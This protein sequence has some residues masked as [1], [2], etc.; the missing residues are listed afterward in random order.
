MNKKN[1]CKRSILWLS[2]I[3]LCF[4]TIGP[5]SSQSTSFNDQAIHYMQSGDPWQVIQ[6]FELG[7]RGSGSE[8]RIARQN[9]RSYRQEKDLPPHSWLHFGWIYGLGDMAQRMPANFW[10]LTSIMLLFI[11]IRWTMTWHPDSIKK[12]GICLVGSLLLMGMAYC[13]HVFL[14]A[15][16][17]RIVQG[18]VPLYIR[19][20]LG[21]EQIQTLY[22]GQMAI[23]LQQDG[24][25]TQIETDTYEIGWVTNDVLIPIAATDL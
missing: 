25:F 7:I 3:L 6:S 18:D 12:V 19:P 21:A 20:Y 15:Q 10:W 11:A 13:R 16:D 23:Q 24:D 14:S 1:I 4:R 5:I 17:V 22:S 2:I 8:K 9:V